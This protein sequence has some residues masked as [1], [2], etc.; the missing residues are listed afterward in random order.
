[1]FHRLDMG[2][3]LLLTVSTE[4]EE[5]FLYVVAKFYHDVL[6]SICSHDILE[7][8]SAEMKTT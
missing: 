1:M 8:V 2:F 4:K 3:S 6:H 5:S 7:H